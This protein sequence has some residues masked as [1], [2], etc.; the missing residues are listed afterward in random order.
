MPGWNYLESKSEKRERSF[1]QSLIVTQH[2][3]SSKRSGS[4]ET[5]GRG[6]PKRMQCPG[7]QVK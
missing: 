1:G 3:E 2:W 6:K 7:G 5:V 4:K